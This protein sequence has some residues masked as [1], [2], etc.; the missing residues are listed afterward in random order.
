VLRY[1][2]FEPF[3][4][5]IVDPKEAR[6]DLRG[7]I[8]IYDCETGD[9]RE[10]TVTAKVLEKYRAAWEEYLDEA[11]RFCTSRQ[12]SYFRADVETSFD[13][14]ILRVFRRGGFLR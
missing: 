11:Q 5:H 8:R 1:N 12:V 6:P 9:E 7:D 2:K 13:E 3:V 4:L 10:V 14:L